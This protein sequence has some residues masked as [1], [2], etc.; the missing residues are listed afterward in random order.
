MTKRIACSKAGL[1]ACE[2]CP[3]LSHSSASQKRGFRATYFLKTVL[4]STEPTILLPSASCRSAAKKYHPE[5]VF[6]FFIF[7]FYFTGE[8]SPSDTEQPRT[9]R[10]RSLRWGQ[11]TD[12]GQTR[13]H[14]DSHLFHFC[15]TKTWR[16]INDKYEGR[17]V[18]FWMGFTTRCILFQ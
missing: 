13:K 18:L 8:L 15:E 6:V 3:V 16:R 9:Y 1:S 5:F 12:C 14:S 7:F 10:H 4:P 17:P 2:G 11:M